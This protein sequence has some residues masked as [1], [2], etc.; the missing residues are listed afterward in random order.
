[1][2]RAT[3]RFYAELNDFLPPERRGTEFEYS[4]QFP[5]AAKDLVEAIGVPHTEID[6]LVVNGA[7][8]GFAQVIEGGEFISVYPA[9][10]SLDVSRVSLVR[11]EPLE[12][13]RFV[14][15]IHLGQLATYLRM[16]GFD[17]LYR[18]DYE[19]EELAETSA[20]ERRI[21]LTQDRGLLKRGTVRYGYYVRSHEPR[22]QF[23][24]VLRRYDLFGSTAP[25]SRCLECNAGLISATKEQVWDRLPEKTREL[26]SEFLRCPCC[27]RV[28]WKGS[29]YEHMRKFLDRVV[30]G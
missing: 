5:A 29:H 27:Q 24:E 10:R 6:L 15:D 18:N 8:V 16:A 11:A 7:S 13:P 1:M 21:L 28:F 4:F 25:F 19:D 20:R 3:F 9:F 26:F 2:R 14:L 12:C 17:T 30:S 22:E 23:A